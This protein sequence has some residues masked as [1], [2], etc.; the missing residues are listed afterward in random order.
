MDEPITLTGAVGIAN[1][2]A[3]DPDSWPVYFKQVPTR[4]VRVAGPFTVLTSEG[5]LNCHDGYIA[6]DARGYPYPIA[7]D[8]FRLIYGEHKPLD[9]A[10]LPPTTLAGLAQAHSFGLVSK[11]D[12]VTAARKL[13]VLHGLLDAETSAQVHA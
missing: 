2:D 9:V 11:E 7:A 12:G 13:L 3:L 1:L 8:E 10:S 6:I 4:A 5:E